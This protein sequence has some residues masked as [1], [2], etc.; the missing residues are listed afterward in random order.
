MKSTIVAFGVYCQ[1]KGTS[2]N[3]LCPLRDLKHVAARHEPQQNGY[4]IFKAHN[5]ADAC[6]R[7][8]PAGL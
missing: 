4:S 2:I 8:R 5:A 7:S 1:L 6:F 3:C